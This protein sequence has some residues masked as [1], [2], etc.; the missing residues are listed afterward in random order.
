MT[1][2]IAIE[3]CIGAGKTELAKKL[4]A[5]F[6]AH[7]LLERFNENLFLPK[8]YENPKQYA[9][10]LEI[11]FLEDRFRQIEELK[12]NNFFD[13]HTIVSDYFIEKCLIFSRNNLQ[14]EEYNL[15]KK[16]FELL[17]PLLPTPSVVL[18]LYRTPEKLLQN[19]HHRGRDYEQNIKTDYL[20]DIQNCYIDYLKNYNACPVKI[21]DVS[22]LDFV[23]NYDDYDY[24]K[25]II[26]NL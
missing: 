5:S 25:N 26:D 4:S 8:F 7:L 17:S 13:C 1:T 12:K 24:L 23:T 16:L 2:F 18:Y 3:G 10:P 6:N 22:D 21:M 11:S 19:I 20:E 15:Y 14:T 9:F